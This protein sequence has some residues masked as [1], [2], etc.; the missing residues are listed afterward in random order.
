MLTRTVLP[1]KLEMSSEKLTAHGGLALVAECAEG[2]GLRRDFERW[3]PRAGSNR[4]HDAWTFGRSSLLM[5]HGGG[6]T[7]EDLRMLSADEALQSALGLAVPSPDALRRWLHRVGHD[8]GQAR[9][10]Q[11]N[12]RLLKR[13][14]AQSRVRRHTLDIDATFVEANKKE[15]VMSYHGERGYYPMLGW[16]A[17]EGLCI[18]HEMRAGNVAP[19]TDNAGFIERCCAALPDGHSIKLV[20]SDAAGYSAEVIRFCQRHDIDFVIRATMNERVRREAMALHEQAW[21]PLPDDLGAGQ[22][23]ETLTVMGGVD[24]AIRLIVLRRPV[25]TEMFD[26]MALAGD[27]HRT[28]AIATSMTCSAAD[29]VRRYNARGQAENLIKELKVGYAMERMPCGDFCANAVWLGL[30]VLAYNL[31]QAL[32]LFVLGSDW[33]RH[34]VVTLRWRLYNT[35]AR[36]V[37]HA[38]AV[39]LKISGVTAE[40]F[41]L[42]CRARATMHRLYLLADTA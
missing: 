30:G 2:F 6:R 17:E 39:I 5:L 9:M 10:Q 38:G 37:R 31:G 27:D 7:M 11:I 14:L 42:L 13:I 18:G 21:Q 3:M 32:K 28:F 33:A 4:G 24:A 19:A 41:D 20:R 15:A 29:V 8:D 40:T 34:T 23:A 16:L 35:A 22:I 36:L 26:D 25:Q 1:F 12:R